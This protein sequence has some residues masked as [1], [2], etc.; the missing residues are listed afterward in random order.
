MN[1]YAPASSIGWLDFDTA[2]SERVATLL[3]SLDE[4]ATL[5]I[6]GLG[7]VRDA[8]SD[9]LSPGT[10]TIQTRLRY[11][12]FLPWIFKQ[13]EDQRVPAADFA[14]RLRDDEARLI[15]CMRQLGSNQGVIGFRAGRDLKRMPSD[16]YWGCL[17]SWGIRRLPL[18]LAEYG[19]RAASLGRLQPQ[20]DDDGN[21][22]K[23]GVSMWAA[24]P[25]P[26]PD[27]LQDKDHLRTFP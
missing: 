20:L 17:G 19:A 24:I 25:P 5:D 3:R 4:P 1:N 15:D 12:V 9:M 11:V 13:L 22:T 8:F 6:L 7:T 10:S 16:V 14:R 26:P 18:S 27:F 21:A 23:R 2:A